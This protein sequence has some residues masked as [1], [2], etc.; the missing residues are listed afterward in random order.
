MADYLFNG[1]LF[2]RLGNAPA[3]VELLPGDG[4]YAAAT[5]DGITTTGYRFSAGAGLQ[6]ATDGLL[7][8]DE[9]TIAIVMALDQVFGYRKIVDVAALAFDRGFY[10][11]NS[12]LRFYPS[13]YSQLSPFNADTYYQVVLS[14]SADGTTTGYIDGVQQLTLDDTAANGVISSARLLTFFRD[15]NATGNSENAAGMVLRIRVFD[16]A[17]DAGEVAELENNRASEFTFRDRFEAL[18]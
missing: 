14:R 5:L 15:D 10:I 3:L 12:A 1:H 7:D 6:L 11:Y 8:N 2:D 4:S 17:L 16:Q 9:Y 13:G 18:P